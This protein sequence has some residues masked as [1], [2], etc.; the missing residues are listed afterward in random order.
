MTTI[1]TNRST[2]GGDSAGSLPE[3]PNQYDYLYNGSHADAAPSRHSY[4]QPVGPVVVNASTNRGSSADSRNS[5]SDS[6]YV[7]PNPPSVSS[8]SGHV[9]G[10]SGGYLRDM[11]LRGVGERGNSARGESGGSA[12]RET[13]RGAPLVLENEVPPEEHAPAPP[14]H[15][16]DPDYLTPS[17]DYLSPVSHI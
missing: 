17:S 6:S 11:V 10:E 8:G 16:S 3:A 2:P 5:S 4:L 7:P 9:T 14:S 15:S 1:R 12:S 13:M